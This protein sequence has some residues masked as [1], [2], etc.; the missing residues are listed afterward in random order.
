MPEA[1]VA[2]AVRAA[3]GRPMCRRDTKWYGHK[4]PLSLRRKGPFTYYVIG[5]E[6][7]WGMKTDKILILLIIEC[8]L[9]I[10]NAEKWGGGPKWSKMGLR[11]MW[12]IPNSFAS[13]R[14][15]SR[16]II[17]YA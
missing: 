17:L 9:Y 6:G 1:T 7:E 8:L 4:P 12:T 13:R 11:N 2:L 15:G 16:R 3:K 14:H 10:T 5:R